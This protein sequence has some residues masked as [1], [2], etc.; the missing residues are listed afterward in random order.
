MLPIQLDMALAAL[1]WGTRDLAS[2]AKVSLDTIARFKRGDELKPRTI[3]AMQQA[4]EAAGITFLADGE[5]TGGGP[6]V[7]LK[8]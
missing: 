1:K 4:L 6:G 8:S 5:I 2:A 7:R 3:E